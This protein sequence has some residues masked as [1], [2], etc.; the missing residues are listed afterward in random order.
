VED[1]WQVVIGAGVLWYTMSGRQVLG[2][3]RNGIGRKS[4]RNLEGRVGG[5]QIREGEVRE[6]GKVSCWAGK[7]L[8]SYPSPYIKGRNV[9]GSR[10]P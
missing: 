10:K 9:R 4:S 3:H 7:M 8:F 6:H 2:G 1:K 5:K